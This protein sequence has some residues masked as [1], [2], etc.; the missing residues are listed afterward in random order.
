MFRATLL[1]ALLGLACMAAAEDQMYASIQP[2]TYTLTLTFTINGVTGTPIPCNASDCLPQV[3][4]PV[5]DSITIAYSGPA[6]APGNTVSLMSC[7][8][9]A[10]SK[11]RA[12]RKANAAIPKDKQCNVAKPFK[13]GL[14]TGSGSFTWTPG[15]NT[16][17]A[18][19]N[20]QLLE[21]VAGSS[22]KTY[23]AMGKS[24]GFYTIIP[25]NSRPGWLMAMTGIF[26]AI[27]PITL[28]G[29]FTYEKIY[30][31]EK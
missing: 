19:Y 7:F 2:P 22:P 31:K 24:A 25:I 13:T 16:P 14:P 17:P 5:H 15:P 30:K 29:F 12:W 8:A 26:C 6:G 21:V 28:A 1:L 3:S 18:T 20:I 11:N 4:V 27:G 9:P 10:S 23:A